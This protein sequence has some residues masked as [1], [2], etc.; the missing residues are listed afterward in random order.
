MQYGDVS[1]ST[2]AA[3]FFLV[4]HWV[5]TM[6]VCEQRESFPYKTDKTS[7]EPGS[8]FAV[9]LTFFASLFFRCLVFN[10]VASQHTHTQS[11]PAWFSFSISLTFSLSPCLSPV[12]MLTP[13]DDV[14][15]KVL[16]HILDSFCLSLITLTHVFDSFLSFR[17]LWRMCIMSYLV[18]A[19]NNHISPSLQT[20]K[21][22]TVSAMCGAFRYNLYYIVLHC[23]ALY[24][25]G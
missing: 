1:A 21:E 23:I 5:Y 22:E 3:S 12:C 16:K 13:Q 18:K 11:A 9:D 17:T 4:A 2:L 24:G 8:F 14:A 6:C 15:S 7:V 25:A 20:S 10:G 19:S